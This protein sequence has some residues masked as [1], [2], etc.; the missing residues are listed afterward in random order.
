MCQFYRNGGIEIKQKWNEIKKKLLT[1]SANKAGRFE[2][3]TSGQSI[4]Q[5]T[6]KRGSV[7]LWKCSKEHAIFSNMLGNWLYTRATVL[8]HI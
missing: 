5:E 6:E 8:F 7:L 2:H 4:E 1:H 3:Q